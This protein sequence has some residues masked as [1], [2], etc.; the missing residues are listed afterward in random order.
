MIKM[1]DIL[2]KLNLSP[3]NE[4][5]IK[6]L[7][8]T[9]EIFVK[10]NH[11]ENNKGRNKTM[12]SDIFDLLIEHFYMG[13]LKLKFGENMGF[14]DEAIYVDNFKDE[15]S[16]ILITM[17]KN[18]VSSYFNRIDEVY[19][20]IDS[21]MYKLIK[22]AILNQDM[23]LLDRLSNIVTK[24]LLN[25]VSFECSMERSKI[26]KKDFARLMSEN[27]SRNKRLLENVCKYPLNSDLVSTQIRN[28][29]SCFSS[30]VFNKAS[31]REKAYLMNLVYN[32]FAFSNENRI[33]RYKKILDTSFTNVDALNY[34]V[35]ELA[36][37]DNDNAL[38]D[39]R[40]KKLLEDFKT[41]FKYIIKNETNKDNIVEL[42][43]V[44][45][46]NMKKK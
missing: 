26:Y 46:K 25:G 37:K 36:Y 28:V 42:K 24:E 8:L 29:F 18:I 32:Y 41:G 45:I 14:D 2:E 35:N 11:I 10:L 9:N 6:E 12:I 34:I 33:L 17:L 23:E 22:L 30:D 38:N 7:N 13:D 21:E 3:L 19:K 4:R 15:Y 20:N 44:S 16:D 5:Q 31:I 39:I 1:R 40:N 27:T 43:K